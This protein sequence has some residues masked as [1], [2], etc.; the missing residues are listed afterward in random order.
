MFRTAAFARNTVGLGLAALG[1]VMLSAVA[2]LAPAAA[3]QAKQVRV[4]RIPI[5]P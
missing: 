4:S 2:D 5:A 3:Q 1:L